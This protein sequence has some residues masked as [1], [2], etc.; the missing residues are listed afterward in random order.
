MGIWKL[1]P[2]GCSWIFQS[3]KGIKASVWLSE[4]PRPSL[5]SAVGRPGSSV[6]LPM[7]CGAFLTSHSCFY[8]VHWSD[9]IK[10]KAWCNPWFCPQLE[11]SIGTFHRYNLYELLFI[12]LLL[13]EKKKKRSKSRITSEHKFSGCLPLSARLCFHYRGWWKAL[14][15]LFSY[16]VE[17]QVLL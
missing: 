6:W 9:L 2:G 12:W 16:C 14:A 17:M 5:Q 15:P 8:I 11:A 4:L 7:P 1:A 3:K 13:L 10:H